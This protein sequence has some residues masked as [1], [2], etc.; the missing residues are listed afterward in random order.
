MA[1][2]TILTAAFEKKPGFWGFIAGACLGF[3]ILRPYTVL[4]YSIFRFIETGN[5]EL[6]GRIIIEG[7]R[8]LRFFMLSTSVSFVLLGG[9]IGLI[10]G[11]WYDR[12]K[13]HISARIE[14]EKKEAVLETLRE[15]NVTLSHYI[16]NSSSVI[17]GFAQRGDQ[18]ADNETVKEYFSIIGKEADKTITVMKGLQTLKEIESIKY[19]D[20]GIEMMIDLKKRIEEQLGGLKERSMP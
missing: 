13:R 12:K 3:L 7:P 4:I 11:K 2:K 15:L 19:I 1:L 18:K 5:V 8:A 20:S 9:T 10:F 6:Y 17:R 16:I 14:R